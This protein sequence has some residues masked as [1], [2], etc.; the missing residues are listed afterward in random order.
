MITAE[1]AGGN[2]YLCDPAH[3]DLAT[4]IDRTKLTLPLYLP[5]QPNL[6]TD[7]LAYLAKQKDLWPKTCTVTESTIAS[8][9][10][11]HSTSFVS[12]NMGTQ[13]PIIE[14]TPEGI[15]IWKSGQQTEVVKASSTDLG[16]TVDELEL[17]VRSAREK[18]NANSSRQ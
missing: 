18:L 6:T 14:I 12:V 13:V 15:V 5:D 3:L 7:Q 4:R 11:G 1:D 8:L 16:T 17:A 2:R 9:N 10:D